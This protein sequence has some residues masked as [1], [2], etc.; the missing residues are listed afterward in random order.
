[1]A[2]GSVE[3]LDTCSVEFGMLGVNEPEV[4]TLENVHL[5]PRLPTLSGIVPLAEGITRNP[6]LAGVEIP[7]ISGVSRVQVIIGI[8]T[9]GLHVFSEIRQDGK[10]KLWAWKCPL[11]WVLH[12][13]DSTVSYN[14][15][16]YDNFLVDARADPE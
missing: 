12:G 3:E 16:R 15:K 1:M 2:N 4:F 5:V 14:S 7:V 6:H 8:N 13:C 11:V 10:H 9:P